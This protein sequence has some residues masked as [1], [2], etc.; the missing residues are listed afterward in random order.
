MLPCVVLQGEIG[1]SRAPDKKKRLGSSGETYLILLTYKDTG[2]LF[3]HTAWKHCQK[4][5]S[6][7]GIVV[8]KT[9]GFASFFTSTSNR[10]YV[11]DK[12]S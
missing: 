3:D 10:A 1:M 5:D 2:M 11:T 8:S 7:R 12:H 4:Q 9:D 6:V